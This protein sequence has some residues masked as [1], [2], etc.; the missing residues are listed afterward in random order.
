MKNRIQEAIR[1]SASDYASV[2]N[3]PK[4]TV[5][6]EIEFDPNIDDPSEHG[7]LSQSVITR[8]LR[9]LG[10]RV[11]PGPKASGDRWALTTD[12]SIETQSNTAGLELISPPM[13]VAQAV[14]KLN[15]IFDWMMQR[16]HR[17]NSTTGFHV[18]VSYG[19]VTQT[20]QADPLKVVLLFGEPHVARLFQRELN[21][22]TASHLARL[23]DQLNGTNW[24]QNQEVTKVMDR[25]RSKLEHSKYMSVNLTRQAT[26]GYF[27]FRIMGNTNYHRRFREVMDTI[28]RYGF[29]LQASVD[30]EAHRQEYLRELW[31]V[32]QTSVDAARPQYAN[33]PVKY[34]SLGTD[35]QKLNLH[36]I[37]R[38]RQNITQGDVKSTRDALESLGKSIRD[39]IQSQLRDPNPSRAEAARLSF[40]LLLKQ[41]HVEQE[42]FLQA[43]TGI[44][45]GQAFSLEDVEHIRD[46]LAG[47]KK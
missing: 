9:S 43:L 12:R 45:G 14:E 24:F 21:T 38:F 8:D 25:V 41:H 7:D 17:T 4:V 5:G 40:L 30:P 11:Q 3:D 2:L 33:L 36:R 44:R 10:I 29:V 26:L 31:N 19:G 27:E 1:F 6:Y 23:Q 32:L 13:P 34:A 42:V 35:N 39:A 37:N 47:S 15:M 46:Y 18:G 22:Y 28:L 16:E 20:Q